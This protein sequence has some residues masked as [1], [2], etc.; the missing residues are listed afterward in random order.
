MN[1]EYVVYTYI[2]V[3]VH[4][5]EYY[6]DIK[7]NE[8]LP[9]ATPWMDLEGDIMLSKINQAEKYKYCMISLICGI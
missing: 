7:N 6:S 5:I 1:K 9:C 4:I 3:Y 8:S 2:C